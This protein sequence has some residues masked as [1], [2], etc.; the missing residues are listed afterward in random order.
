M[1]R[2]NSAEAIMWCIQHSEFLKSPMCRLVSFGYDVN[3]MTSRIHTALK[4]G[5]VTRA[6]LATLRSDLSGRRSIFDTIMELGDLTDL[7][8]AGSGIPSKDVKSNG[9]FDKLAGDIDLKLEALELEAIGDGS[10]T[11]PEVALAMVHEVRAET[12]AWATAR[13]WWG[14]AKNA[15]ASVPF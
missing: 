8:G 9:A 7:R 14:A 11:T 4:R 1:H 10:S 2:D 12:P 6:L 3:D 5:P 13:D 15:A